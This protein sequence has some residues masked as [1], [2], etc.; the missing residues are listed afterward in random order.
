MYPYSKQDRNIEEKTILLLSDYLHE[1]SQILH[2]QT[3]NEW[4]TQ[5]NHYAICHHILKTLRNIFTLA[6][7]KESKIDLDGK[8]THHS[9]LK[10]DLYQIDAKE[11]EWVIENINGWLLTKKQLDTLISKYTYIALKKGCEFDFFAGDEPGWWDR[12]SGYICGV[13]HDW[14]EEHLEDI[15]EC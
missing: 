6:D 7:R 8:P 2:Q 1:Y 15:K 5:R 12:D 4:E 9:K 3:T 14:A 13:D 11:I 10:H